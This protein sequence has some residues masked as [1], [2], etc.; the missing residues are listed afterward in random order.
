MKG[1]S[2]ATAGDAQTNDRTNDFERLP[3]LVVVAATVVLLVAGPANFALGHV[4]LGVA[5]IIFGLAAFGAGLAWLAMERR[6]VRESE[7]RT[8]RRPFGPG[9]D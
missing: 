9:T 6:R 7:R 1:I 4:G 3:G 2:R 8:P 5:A